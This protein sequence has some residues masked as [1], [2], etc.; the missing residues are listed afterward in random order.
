MYPS[1]TCWR[2]RRP[3]LPSPAGHG[4]R[5]R[6]FPGQVAI[7]FARE[8]QGRA[9]PQRARNRRD[10]GVVP[11]PGRRR[12]AK[13]HPRFRALG[14]VALHG[15]CCG[16]RPPPGCVRGLFAVNLP[17]PTDAVVIEIHGPYE[18]TGHGYVSRPAPWQFLGCAPA[19]GVPGRLTP[20]RYN[21]LYGSGRL[22]RDTNR[23][24]VAAA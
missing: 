14:E 16:C 11:T 17:A 7:G 19:A 15:S 10:H 3:R 18:A 21:T 20:L 4:V 24:E 6:F 13:D 22:C 23:K 2:S 9:R 1:P 8:R 12:Y 5:V